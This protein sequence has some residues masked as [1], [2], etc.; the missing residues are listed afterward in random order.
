LILKSLWLLSSQD[1]EKMMLD[2]TTD[3]FAFVEIG[4]AIYLRFPKTYWLLDNRAKIGRA[5]LAQ[6]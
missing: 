5:L 1:Y 4:E 2:A 6:V 3:R